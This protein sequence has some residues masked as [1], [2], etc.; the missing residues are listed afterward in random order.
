[1]EGQE[2]ERREG[3][4]RGSGEGGQDSGEEAGEKGKGKG[5]EGYPLRMEILATALLRDTLLT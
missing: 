4:G 1:M 5:R 3:E 2:G